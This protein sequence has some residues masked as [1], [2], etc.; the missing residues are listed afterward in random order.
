MSIRH[1]LPLV[2]AS[3]LFAQ[4]T[5]TT[6]PCAADTTLY[7]DAFGD[8]ANGAG[9]SLFIG[10]NTS[11]VTRRTLVKFDVA[12]ALPA[13]AVIVSCELRLNVTQAPSLT[14]L[15]VAATVH[16]VLSSWNEG[17][18][19]AGAFQGIGAQSTAGDC[20]WIHRNWPS[21][22]WTTPGGDFDP[23]P[24]GVADLPQPQSVTWGVTGSMVGD[25]QSWI[26]NPA[27]NFGWLLKTNELVTREVRRLDSR[28][29]ANTP[30][31]PQLIVTWVQPG[32]WA[33]AGAGCG[34][35]TPGMVGGGSIQV[36]GSLN[37][38]IQGPAFT[39]A[40]SLLN[41]FLQQPAAPIA[42][43]C[44][45]HLPFGSVSPGLRFLLGNGQSTDVLP[46]PANP[47]FAGLTLAA[48]G[49]VLD[50]TQAIGFSL[51]N[52]LFA[53]VQ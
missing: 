5:V 31:R 34:S 47:S 49:A 51:T 42:P 13:D 6:I 20:T 38:T 19:N 16:R 41:F 28:E 17:P 9:N 25:V 2:I 18:A 15:P 4:G 8:T 36:G 12:A 53:V 50:S 45:F 32:G 1:L 3:S 43:G 35:P 10:L 7:L 33:A 30:G 52:G 14:S 48:Q 46:I 37:L 22:F 21:V 26:S 23:T 11:G 44:S 39:P 29:S 27:N 40:L 24:H